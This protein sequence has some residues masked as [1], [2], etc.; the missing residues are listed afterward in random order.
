ME[1]PEDA[2]AGADLREYL[3]L[4]DRSLDVDLT[5]N[6]SDCLSIRGIA[7]DLGALTSQ[8][9]EDLEPEAVTAV[10]SEIPSIRVDAP[11]PVPGMWGGSSARW[12]PRRQRRCGC[13]NACA[14]PGFAVS[15][16]WSTSPT[17]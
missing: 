3:S 16:R 10:R 13:A 1:L 11:R 7:R 6:R 12:T 5:P 14:A 2:P 9:F 15:M 17:T 8:T 4:D